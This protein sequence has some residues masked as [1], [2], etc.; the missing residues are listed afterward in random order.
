MTV[1][2]LLSIISDESGR[3][4]PFSYAANTMAA[5]GVNGRLVDYFHDAAES[6]NK[7]SFD[8]QRILADYRDGIP[9]QLAKA[10]SFLRNNPHAG[11]SRDG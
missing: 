1:D 10:R 7:A 3:I 8:R 2:E 9:Y 5:Y 4:Y 11:V 6:A